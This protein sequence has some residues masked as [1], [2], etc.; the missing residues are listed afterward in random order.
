[1]LTHAGGVGALRVVLQHSG[2]AE[3]RHLTLQVVVD[4]D[5]AGSQVPVNVAHVRQVLHA[6][7]DAMHHAHQLEG[8]HLA[9]TIL[10]GKHIVTH[11]YC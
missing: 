1:M 8:G 10:K 4:Q 11:T 7:G 6:S 3:V 2:Q 5:V 9:I